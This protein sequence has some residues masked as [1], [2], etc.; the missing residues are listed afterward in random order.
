MPSVRRVIVVLA[1]LLLPRAATASPNAHA[2]YS[3]HAT[4]LRG[5]LLSSYDKAVPPT[6]VRSAAYSQ[7][8]T[9]VELQVRFF[10][11]Q[12]VTTTEGRMALKV[13]LRLWWSDTRLAWDPAAYGGITQVKFL[14]ASFSLPEDSEI[15]AKYIAA[16]NIHAVG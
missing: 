13:W 11:V 1:L 5:D 8:G 7:A 2:S 4:T 14:A 16:S 3:T 12:Q 9:D 15:C 10:K 6:S